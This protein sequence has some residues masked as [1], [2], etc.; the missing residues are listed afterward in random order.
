M[1][2]VGGGRFAPSPT[3][4]LH[5]GSLLAAVASYLDARR[6]GVAW[7]VRLDDL[8]TPRNAAGADQA[9]LVALE[10]HGLHWDGPVVRQRERLPR[11][12]EALDV[13]ARQGLLF[14]CR[15]PR[16]RLRD[17]ATYPG[18]CRRHTAPRPDSAVRLRVDDARVSLTD[19]VQGEQH[20]RLAEAGGDFVVRRRDGLFAYQ[21]ATAVDDG[22]G[23]VTRVIRGRD[24]LD[25]T[26]RQVLVMQRLGL[27]VP[28]YGHV[29]LLV[30]RAGR[31]LS[32]QN[33][34]A[35]LD[36]D[37]PA[38]NLRRVLPAL[39]LDGA[40][41]DAGSEALLSWAAG[42]FDLARVPRHDSVS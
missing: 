1:K 37:R 24:L 22:D 6:Q 28:V 38:D 31:K 15:C 11:Y 13:L 5:L 20:W 4:P 36:L 29:P 21:L 2:G 41:A 19:L 23:A 9:I 18:T 27:P 40:P 16:R 8:D 34:A 12:H 30:D 32:K 42:R 25:T 7:H 33:H 14:Y 26:A 10:R 35:P 3:G 39:G 17:H